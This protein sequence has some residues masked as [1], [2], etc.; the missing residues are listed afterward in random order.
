LLIP[1]IAGLALIVLPTA[2]IGRHYRPC[3]AGNIDDFLLFTAD[4]FR[5]QFFC[6]GFEWYCLKQAAF[7]L[8]GL[9]QAVVSTGSVRHLCAELS[10][11][12]CH[13]CYLQGRI[14]KF[15]FPSQFG[16]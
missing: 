15:C 4:F 10:I 7:L 8:T 14:G 16:I 12:R 11:I 13:S 1:T 2:Y 5:N 3:A 9:V 6:G